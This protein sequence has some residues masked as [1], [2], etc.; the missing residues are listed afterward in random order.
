MNTVQRRSRGDLTVL[1]A[2]MVALA[3]IAVAIARHSGGRWIPYGDN[4]L[5]E[6]RI[7]DVFSI[8]HFPLLGTWSSASLTAGTDLNHPGPLLF[9]LLAV[10]VRLFGGGTGVALGVGLLNAVCIAGC[11]AVAYRV[12]GV[13][14]AL[15]V[16]TVAAVLAWT[17]GSTMLTDVWQPHVLML[18]YLFALVLTWAVASGHVRFVVVLAAVCSLLLQTHLGYAF[19]VPTLVLVAVVGAT[20]VTRD[21]RRVLTWTA[22]AAGVTVVLWLPPIIEQLFGDANMSRIIS[23]GSSD[24]PTIGG[25]LAVR[26]MGAVVA[27]PPWWGRSSFA[28]TIVATRYNADGVS[29]SPP[30]L[31]SAALAA[32][33][34]LV[35]VAVLA[36]V[37]RVAHRRG[38]R[39]GAVGVMVAVVM[40]VVGLVSLTISPI[41]ALGLTP[42]QMRWLWPLGAFIVFAVVS[43]LAAA[44]TSSKLRRVEFLAGALAV[45]TAV[46]AIACLPAYIQPAGPETTPEVIP[47]TLEL[48]DD[49]RSYRPAYQVRFETGNLRFAEPWSAVAMSA[50]QQAGVDFRVTDAG[51]ARQ[52]GTARASRGDEQRRVVV[53]EGRQVLERP[54]DSVVLASAGPLESAQI[55]ELRAIEDDLVAWLE[56]DGVWWTEAGER[57]LADGTLGYSAAEMDRFMSDVAWMVRSGA[58]WQFIDNGALDLIGAPDR[59]VEQ[60]TELAR[61]VGLNMT[62]QVVE[63]PLAQGSAMP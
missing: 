45:V 50:L 43:P 37:A 22:I 25:S 46:A 34:V 40:L 28:E 48:A 63:A 21:L 19:L 38:D 15:S 47:G 23:G 17:M 54:A 29:V 44:F 36:A 14:G 20:V 13:I 1:V 32:V 52:L 6:I 59:A 56:R 53:L 55:D 39:P 3:P 18:P 8:D 7:R 33:G 60:G 42:H 4:A 41:G 12:R 31:P 58:V 30:G 61:S 27:L 24:S 51:W 26:L 11:A 57:A 10:P 5:L 2:V 35:V 49:L 16:T 9:L 62:V